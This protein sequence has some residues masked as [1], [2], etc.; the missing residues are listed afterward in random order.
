MQK[1]L[2]ADSNSKD[3]NNCSECDEDTENEGAED[4][5]QN[6]SDSYTEMQRKIQVVLAVPK[7]NC[8]FFAG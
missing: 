7:K 3:D 5:P 1:R 2:F 6:Q 4:L 8:E